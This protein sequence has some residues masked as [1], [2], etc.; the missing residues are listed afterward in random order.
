MS[1][2][3][4]MRIPLREWRSKSW[5]EER[6]GRLENL[7]TEERDTETIAGKFAEA[8]AYIQ[9]AVYWL[10]E[11]N[12]QYDM[13]ESGTELRLMTQLGVHPCNPALDFWLQADLAEGA[14]K[15]ILDKLQ[16]VESLVPKEVAP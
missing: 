11:V 10:T 12:E 8:L 6:E 2:S 13:G 4:K 15:V 14:L 3:R 5:E 9:E 16:R 7:A 1:E